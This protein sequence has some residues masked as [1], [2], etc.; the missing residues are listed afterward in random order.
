MQT[1]V[2]VFLLTITWMSSGTP[3][4]NYTHFKTLAACQKTL[5]SFEQAEAFQNTSNPPG[6]TERWD[7]VCEVHVGKVAG[8]LPT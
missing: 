5:A 3:I 8:K 4:V 6:L 7:A 2:L 1:F